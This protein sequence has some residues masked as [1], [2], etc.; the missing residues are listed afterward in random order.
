M[1]TGGIDHGLA[2]LPLAPGWD[3]ESFRM[4]RVPSHLR[5]DGREVAG[6][7]LRDRFRRAR[8]GKLSAS[9]KGG[10]HATDP[11]NPL[12]IDLIGFE[13]Y[14]ALNVGGTG[15]A[16]FGRLINTTARRPFVRHLLRAFN[17]S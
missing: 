12:L 17:P 10:R 4:S 3:R 15:T 13:F 6:R 1:R 16:S 7:A 14:V 5:Y 11:M 2:L 8:S 9:R